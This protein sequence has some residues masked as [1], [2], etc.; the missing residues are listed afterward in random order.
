MGKTGGGGDSKK[1][2]GN[3]SDAKKRGPGTA[4]P[5]PL[6]PEK[7]GKFPASRAGERG[8]KRKKEPVKKGER[9]K[10]RKRLSG[11]DY[12]GGVKACLNQERD[13]IQDIP[14]DEGERRGGG[15]Q[16]NRRAKTRRTD[17]EKT[18]RQEKKHPVL[19]LLEGF[20]QCE[21]NKGQGGG[22][23]NGRV[24]GKGRRQA[25]P[26]AQQ[27]YP[28]WGQKNEEEKAKRG[29]R[30]SGRERG[31]RR[32]RSGLTSEEIKGTELAEK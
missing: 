4:P 28:L 12:E 30:E 23:D 19:S 14:N 5:P 1:H 27:G 2:R 32:R 16:E 24:G 31:K 18:N 3:G 29:G 26:L 25:A 11:M 9:G 22:R 8:E 7:K 6:V 20:R 21:I 10:E 17:A 13:N 15:T